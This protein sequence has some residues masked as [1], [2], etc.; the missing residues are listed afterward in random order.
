D[1]HI[2]LIIRQML[3]KVTIIEPGDTEFL[4]GELVDR[5]RFEETNAQVVEGGGAPASARPI[6]MGIT[7]ASLATDS[8]LA[9]AS[10]QETTRV[11][12]EAAISA[13]SDPLLGLKENV[14]IGKLIPAG[15]GMGRY[16]NI[17]VRIEDDAIPDYWKAR[18]RELAEAREASAEQQGIVGTMTREEAEQ[19]LGPG[20]HRVGHSRTGGVLP[21]GGGFRPVPSPRHHGSGPSRGVLPGRLEPVCG[22]RHPGSPRARGVRRRRRGRRHDHARAGGPRVR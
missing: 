19:G 8:W 6:L 22:V 10:F 9:A 3:R 14:I 17:R 20:A 11:L 13:R 5:K 7:K 4:P 21:L 15:T 12:T 1:K 16:R 2:E 18:Q